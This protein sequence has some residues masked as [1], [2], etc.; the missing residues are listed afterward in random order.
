MLFSNDKVMWDRDV[1]PLYQGDCHV[2]W[3]KRSDAHPSL[4]RLINGPERTRYQSFRLQEDQDRSLVSYAL[5]RILLSQYLHV[6][7]QKV[8]IN[9]TCS[10]CGEPHGKPYLQAPFAKR[11]EMSVSHS[12]EMILVAI[13]KSPLGIDIEKVRE[14]IA[15]EKMIKHVLS[16][17]EKEDFYAVNNK[18]EA[19]YRYWTRK[20]AITKALG[21]GI[22]LPLTEIEVTGYQELP[23]F[24]SYKQQ[25]KQSKNFSMRDLDFGREYASSL[26]VI[27]PLG[28][29]IIRNATP[30]IRAFYL[31]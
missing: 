4:I 23:R 5:L 24:L 10:Q 27:G 15:V 22:V 20:E 3:A 8:P 19:F 16:S 12:G 7:P 29:P 30:L 6:E 9:R 14:D 26:A 13:A 31:S 11:L 28:N 25:C 17:R 21:K 1:D 18:L 2:W